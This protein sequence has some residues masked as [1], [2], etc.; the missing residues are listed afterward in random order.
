MDQPASVFGAKAA[1]ILKESFTNLPRMAMEK[2]LAGAECA[3]VE[4]CL[5]G[6]LGLVADVN[7]WAA[8][9]ARTAQ[10]LEKQFPVEKFIYETPPYADDVALAP[11][12]AWAAAKN[13]LVAVGSGAINDLCKYASHQ[14]GI[15]YVVF[16]TAP[17]MNGYL[18]A[19]ASLSMQGHKHSQA[20]TLPVGIFADLSVLS[21][22]PLRLIRAGLGDSLART[23]AQ[24]DWL[25][26]HLLL[27]TPYDARPFQLLEELEPEL[28]EHATGLKHGDMAAVETLIKVLLLSGLGMTLCGGSYP[29]S[30]GEHAIA[31][32]YEMAFGEA[33]TLHGEQI[34]VTALDVARLQHRLLAS[35]P[36]LLKRVDVHAAREKIEAFYGVENADDIVRSYTKKASLI[37]DAV[38]VNRR[39]VE[40]WPEISHH[41][42][43]V[44]LLDDTMEK[45]L[46]AVDAP[47][48]AAALGWVQEN[49]TAARAHAH[50][51]RD[52]F[53]FLDL[54]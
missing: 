33:N 44:M 7:T 35:P 52:R 30:Q 19:N 39:L 45:A 36:H 8:L 20:A 12:Q 37:G 4:P 5:T 21:S 18:S 53:G 2:S 31:H 47:R 10:A 16:P 40:N 34:A 25:L 6:A 14:L 22:A 17:S 26:S 50:L 27:D 38:A 23:C 49:Y 46:M 9:G 54:L 41:I 32:A 28:L 3:L 43:D 13:G 51:L 42:R 11:L 48:D 29:A 1:G 24:A 15:P